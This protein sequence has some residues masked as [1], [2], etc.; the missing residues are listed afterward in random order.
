MQVIAETD[1]DRI[2]MVE[3][4]RFGSDDFSLEFPGGMMDGGETPEEAAAR[5]LEEETGFCGERPQLIARMYPNPAIQ[6]NRVNVVLM[7]N[8]R[9]EKPTKFDEFENLKAS[10]VT[11]S[12]LI[13]S[14][15][16]GKISHCIVIAAIAKY[17]LLRGIPTDVSK[18][19]TF[20]EN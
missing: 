8:C 2:V 13:A 4:F 10:T 6:T 7:E 9:K 14:V 12:D 1:D 3:Q 16:A 18:R 20:R 17:M 5:E 11:P 19:R 15:E